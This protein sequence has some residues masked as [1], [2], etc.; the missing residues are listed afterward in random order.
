MEL[1][2]LRYL[3]TVAKYGQMT[4]AAEELHISQ[5]SLSK[6]IATLEKD[7]G[8]QLFDRLGNRIVLN[9]V[10]RVFLSRIDRLLLGLDDAVREANASDL[11]D[12]HFAV[13]T[14]GLCTNFID[15]FLREN[16]RVRLRQ[17]LMDPEQ[18]AAALERGELDCAVCSTDL[19]SE[20]IRW[21]G[22]VEDEL[23]LLISK[24]HP[25][26]D[27]DAIPLAACAQE[28]FICNNAG[29]DSRDLL[30][31]HCRLAGFSPNIVFDGNEPE[32]AFQLVAG[33]HGVMMMSSIVYH[34]LMAM[35]II[36][37]PL[38]YI[39]AMHISRPVCRR[40]MGIAVLTHHYMSKTT[41]LF[42]RGLTEYFST[43]PAGRP[44]KEL[45]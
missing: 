9:S 28:S 13:N 18:M 29:F 19:S 34:W 5:S 27:Q 40:P 44:L 45:G 22:L 35:E 12:I 14:S 21:T 39:T 24:Q 10:G 23:L 38:H 7:L 1:N 2:Q 26:A 16:P 30:L 15:R 4:K 36:N 17:S 37:P 8:V 20:H 43:L 6:T 41:E 32:L 25:L 31:R 33:N 11:G 3:Q 42:I